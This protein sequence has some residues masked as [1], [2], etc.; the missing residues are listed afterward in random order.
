MVWRGVTASVPDVCWTQAASQSCKRTRLLP[1]GPFMPHFHCDLEQA[2]IPLRHVWNHTIGSG[3]APLA[4]RADWQGQMRRTRADLKCRYARFHGILSDDMGTLLIEQGK[5]VYGFFN[6]DQI[7]DFLLEIGMRPFVELSFMPTALSSGNTGV[8]KYQGNVTP[9]RHYGQWAELISHLVRHWI[10]RYGL[11]EVQQWYFEVWNEPNLRS[12]WTGSQKDYFKLYEHTVHAIK[13]IDAAL[14]VGGPATASNGWIAEFV[15]FCAGHDLP[16][17]FVSTHHYPTDAFGKPGDDTETQLAQA[18]R[19]VL[20]QR[21]IDSSRAAGGKPLFYTEWSS[22]SNPFFHH[23]DEPYAAA[24]LIKNMLEVTELV[25]GYS[26]WAFS[27]IFEENY[28][29]SVPFHGGFGLQTIH[30]VAKP[31]YRACQLLARLGHE[32]LLVDGLHATVNA[33]VIRGDEDVSVVLSNHVFPGHEIHDAKVRLT[34][35]GEMPQRAWVERIDDTHCN[36]R[37]LWESWGAPDYPDARQLSNLHEASRLHRKN[38]TWTA[39]DKGID[40]A[41]TLPAHGVAVVTLD[42]PQA[43]CAKD[44]R[45]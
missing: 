3:H 9:P 30:G 11:D 15:D 31:A 21:V 29:S 26:W 40:L 32:S 23:H 38:I 45:S 44:A 41:L 33:W 17:D 2:G 1:K 39:H 4:L 22:S 5:R 34:L 12:F 28:L 36:P 27:D 18:H 8:F 7:M 43:A 25:H 19:G 10:D 24:F 13:S 14:C 37:A 6:A 35:L 42:Y 20:R 16:A